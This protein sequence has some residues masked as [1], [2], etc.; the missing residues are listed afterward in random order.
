MSFTRRAAL[1]AAT[2]TT[3]LAALPALSHG[4]KLGDLEIGHP[5]ARAT[6]PAAKV[7]G[8]YL[9]ITNR[10]PQPDRLV[11]ATFEG[12]ASVEVHEMSHENGVM[13]MRELRAGLEIKPGEAVD[14]KP[15]GYHLMFIGLKGPLVEKQRPKGVL[16][17][18]RA[19]RI[20]V[21]FAVEGIGGR[22]N[23]HGGGHDHHAP[24]TQ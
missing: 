5:W 12:S 8:G 10:G 20:E 24:R 16:I 1:I 19:G 14:F 17:F 18:E 22:G 3:A 7:G 11:S 23:E 21:E 13:R 2:C 9:K 6:P 15:G 4:Y